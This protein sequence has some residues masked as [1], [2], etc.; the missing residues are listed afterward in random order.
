MPVTYM[1]DE[2]ERIA[3][4][5]YDEASDTHDGLEVMKALASDDRLKNGF[6]ILADLR[7]KRHIPSA[8]EARRLA[9]TSIALLREY[10]VALVVSAM[11]QYGMANMMSTLAGLYGGQVRGFY[12]PEKAKEWLNEAA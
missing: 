1:I 7:R 5:T 6:G 3:Y 9:Q 2:A 8:D 10:K 12:D 4:V 11:A